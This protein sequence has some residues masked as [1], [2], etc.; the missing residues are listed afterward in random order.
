MQPQKRIAAIA[1]ADL[2]LS[3][4]PPIARSCE[5]WLAAQKRSIDQLCLLAEVHRCPVLCAGDVTDK[6]TGPPELITF[7]LRNLPTMVAVAGNHDLPNHDYKSLRKSVYGV[8]VEAGKIVNLEPGR[9]LP[10]HGDSAPIRIHG[11]PYG[12]EPTP[13]KADSLNIEIALVHK[14]VWTEATGSYPGAPESG[15]LREFKKQVAGY[16]VVII[17]DNHTPFGC[18][19]EKQRIVNVGGFLR[20]K[21]DEQNHKPSVVLIYSDGM[22][23]R[24]HL[25][26][27]KDQFVDAGEI[28][29]VLSGI[30]CQT[31][32]EALS[33]LGAAAI[34]F[35][36]AVEHT[37]EREKVAD[38]VKNLIR[39][40]LNG[41]K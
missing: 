41:D 35:A 21:I 3:L 11:F 4:K 17:G 40:Y 37:M 22:T 18:A 29:K 34:D 1:C 9:P 7:L 24:H 32:I 36:A 8:L 23:V 5:D 30:G 6:A 26:C 28:E 15:R 16:D 12:T 39:A 19:S 31:F 25:D 2:H 20:R 33:D 27:S 13:L 10:I 38:A 14:Y